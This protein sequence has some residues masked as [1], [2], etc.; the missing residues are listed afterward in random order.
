MNEGDTIASSKLSIIIH[1]HKGQRRPHRA[2]NFQV[3]CVDVDTR[4]AKSLHT[5]Q[6]AVAVLLQ[7][8]KEFD[9]KLLGLKPD[10]LALVEAHSAS[11]KSEDIAMVAACTVGSDMALTFAE[12]KPSDIVPK[13]ASFFTF[14][15]DQLHMLKKNIPKPLVDKMDKTAKDSDYFFFGH[16]VLCFGLCCGIVLHD[17]KCLKQTGQSFGQSQSTHQ[18]R[19]CSLQ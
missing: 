12:T 5:L 9:Q 15:A 14:C 16:M 17:I 1:S 7:W 3:W 11:P 2:A 18:E 8:E 13:V 10:F 6:E 19:L 4:G